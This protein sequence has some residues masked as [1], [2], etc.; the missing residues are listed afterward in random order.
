MRR[1]LRT[2]VAVLQLVTLQLIAALTFTFA[3]PSA[4]SHTPIEA[5]ASNSASSNS[6]SHVA[7]TLN[8]SGV[9]RRRARRRRAADALTPGVWGGEHIRFE[10]TENGATIEYDCAHGTVEGRILVDSA[11]RFNVAG[12]HFPEHGGPI[13]EGEGS[14]GQPVRINGRVGGSLIHLNVTRA[15]TSLGSFDLTRDNEGRVFKCR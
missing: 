1:R 2:T 14:T 8:T 7:R 15:G 13:R 5:R 6:A 12:K 4:G 11:G 3:A 9:Q 10:V